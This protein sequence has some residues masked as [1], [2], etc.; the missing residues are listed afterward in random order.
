MSETDP[1]VA[2]EP[3]MRPNL[4]RSRKYSAAS[5]AD[6]AVS[7]LSPGGG[8]VVLGLLSRL[9]EAWESPSAAR[10]NFGEDLTGAGTA[11]ADCFR[12][13]AALCRGEAG[14][15]DPEVDRDGPEGWKTYRDQIDGRVRATYYNPY[16]GT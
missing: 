16:W 14:Q 9:D 6:G 2:P 15:E 5:R 8:N 13:Q 12:A 7:V 1:E 10:R 4:L 11:V 3:D